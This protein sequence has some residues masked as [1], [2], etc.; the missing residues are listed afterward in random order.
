MKSWDQSPLRDTALNIYIDGA[1]K[2]NP[3]EAGAGVWVADGEGKKGLGIES[4]PRP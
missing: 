1:S 2:G 4:V 3:G